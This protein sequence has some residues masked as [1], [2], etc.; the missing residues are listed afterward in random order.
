MTYPRLCRSGTGY[1]IFT[2]VRRCCFGSSSAAATAVSATCSRI[3]IKDNI[4][5]LN[6]PS[7]DGKP[8]LVSDRYREEAPGVGLQLQRPL[9]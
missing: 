2:K 4:H 9:E 5:N 3:K 6:H 8:F 1:G 7:E